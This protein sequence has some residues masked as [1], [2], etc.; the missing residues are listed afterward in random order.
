MSQT[1]KRLKEQG[2]YIFLLLVL[3]YFTT[4]GG[5]IYGV[6]DFYLGLISHL[7]AGGIIIGYFLWKLHQGRLLPRTPLDLP[8]L[9]F[10][11]ANLASTLL[12]TERRLSA[13]NLLFLTTFVLLYYLAVDLLV[14]GRPALLLVKALLMV[15]AVVIVLAGL[16]FLAWYFGLLPLLNPGDPSTVGW[17][18]IG[19]LAE[20]I[21]PKIE[22]LHLTLS[23]ANAL[24]WF[25]A[26]LIPLALSQL[27][28]TSVRKTRLNLALWVL[29]ASVV[30]LLTFSRNG[31]LS[32]AT[33]IGVFTL[34]LFLK[35][36]QQ[37]LRTL[38]SR[39]RN[40]IVLALTLAFLSIAALAWPALGWLVS[41]RPETIEVRWELW[42][43][44]VEIARQHWLFGGGFG[45]FGYLFHQVTDFDPQA[46]D[47][48]FNT[49]HNAY[50]NL[51]AETGLLGLLAGLWLMVAA[52]WNGWRV[53][54]EGTDGWGQPLSRRVRLT[55]L[56][57]LSGLLAL[58][59][60]N[61]FDDTWVYPLTT[62]LCV[63]LTAISVSPCARPGRRATRAASLISTIAVGALMATILWIDG[64]HY[65][66]AQGVKAALGGDWWAASQ[67]L[68]RAKDLDPAFTLY[69]YQWGVVGGNLALQ[70][71][72]P[73]AL[74]AAIYPYEQETGRGGDQALNHSNLAWLER[75]GGYGEKALGH[76]RRAVTLAP[77]NPRYHLSLGF[78][79]EEGGEREKA[80]AEYA[81]A[82]AYRPS[83]LG[84]GFWHS[85]TYRQETRKVLA[86]MAKTL[87]QGEP[88]LSPE[89]IALSLAQLATYEKKFEEAL[90][91]LD[92]LPGSAPASLLQAQVQEAQGETTLALQSLEEA[93]NLE[94]ALGVAYLERGKVSLSQGE[95]EEATRDL[96]TAL[97]LGEETA[98]YY[99]GE[100]A[101]REGDMEKALFEF[102]R[103]LL[104]SCSLGYHYASFVYHRENLPV[105]FSPALLRC[106]PQDDLLPVYLQMA[107]AYR[108]S[109]QEEK[110]EEICDWLCLFYTSHSEEKKFSLSPPCD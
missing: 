5:T 95:E 47:I 7:V 73:V 63:L 38:L 96:L 65:F 22:R 8:I 34:A 30:F 60:A 44:A 29:M 48:F 91:Y 59:V 97:F 42:R 82:V 40:A 33:G 2:G 102:Q 80:L 75:R 39:R 106:L 24:S 26:S 86:P 92:L 15:G 27:L 31:F 104:S 94:P 89:E 58:L 35:R 54:W 70:T 21:P 93:L 77:R 13:E 64:A 11:L 67:A 45:T 41:L 4:I 100:V 17:W 71:G 103:G 49:A 88:S 107:D 56:G 99:L 52:V 53:W 74:Q 84:S 37:R 72:D 43:A 101:Y 32:M 62:L 23:N 14:N 50:L 108:Q 109:G 36:N 28:A 46:R 83:L 1:E 87:L 66:Y 10:L 78:L 81:Q 76:M 98:H 20:P 55:T 90:N 19:G 110:G 85:N 3:T 18:S 51:A 6:H 25:L 57:A 61:L 69:H 12:S 68:E 105:D 79:W 9:F 16:E